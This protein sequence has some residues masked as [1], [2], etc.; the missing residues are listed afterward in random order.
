L[1]ASHTLRLR[2]CIGGPSSQSSRRMFV[3]QR[4]VPAVYF[5]DP[6]AAAW[7]LWVRVQIA[8]FSEAVEGRFFSASSLSVLG[9]PNGG[10][11]TK[12]PFSRTHQRRHVPKTA[13]S[14]LPEQEKNNSENCREPDQYPNHPPLAGH[15]GAL[16]SQVRWQCLATLRPAIL[17]RGP[18]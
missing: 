7:C 10:D 18:A 17:G 16:R 14:V 2:P 12:K 5:K 8:T 13:R 3:G 4:E 1:H 11:L 15:R 9:V 6:S